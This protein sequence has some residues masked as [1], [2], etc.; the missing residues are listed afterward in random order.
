[1]IVTNNDGNTD[2]T[3]IMRERGQKRSVNQVVIIVVFNM[4]HRDQTLLV[5]MRGINAEINTFLMKYLSV[6]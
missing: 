5:I 3:S 6:A 1:M 2:K 4:P